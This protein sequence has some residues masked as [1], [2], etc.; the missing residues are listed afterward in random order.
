MGKAIVQ[1]GGWFIYSKTDAIEFVSAC[2]QQSIVILGIDGFFLGKDTVQPSL[3]D[4]V[5]YSSSNTSVEN[6]YELAIDFIK[7]RDNKLFFQIV[8]SD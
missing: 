3:E 1:P 2:E 8:C 7:K 5:D 4:S 6:I